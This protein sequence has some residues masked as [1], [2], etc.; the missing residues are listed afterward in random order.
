VI[1]ILDGSRPRINGG[2]LMRETHNVRAIAGGE[3]SVDDARA[4]LWFEAVS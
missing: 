4:T 2:E 1:T 3:T